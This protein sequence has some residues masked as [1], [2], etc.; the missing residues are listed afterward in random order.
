[1]WE[2]WVRSLGWEDPLEE[3]MA[4]HSSVLAWRI[5]MDRHLAGY[6]LWGQMQSVGHNR[7]TKHKCEAASHFRSYRFGQNCNY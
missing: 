5:P 6:S 4:I 7:A 3:G 1:M 2:P